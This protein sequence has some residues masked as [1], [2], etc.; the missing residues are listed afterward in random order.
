VLD[1]LFDP[2]FRPDVSRVR[3]TGGA[4][5]GLAI[6]KSAVEACRGSVSLQNRQPHGLELSL[7][8]PQAP[9]EALSE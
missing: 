1:R 4:G 7:I 3:E 6:V 2:F 9:A 5:L 8:L